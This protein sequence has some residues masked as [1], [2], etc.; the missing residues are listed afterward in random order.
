MKL[1]KTKL[2]RL[3][4][5]IGNRIINRI[6]PVLEHEDVLIECRTIQDLLGARA[7]RRGSNLCDISEG[8]QKLPVLKSFLDVGC[9]NGSIALA[10]LNWGYL[11]PNSEIVLV[12]ADPNLCNHCELHMRLNGL[13]NF[14]VI[15]AYVGDPKDVFHTADISV[16]GTT[17]PTNLST[18]FYTQ[19]TARIPRFEFV[20]PASGWP[21]DLVNID[22]EGG[23]FELMTNLAP[24]TINARYLFV[25]WHHPM[26]DLVSIR[27]WLHPHYRLFHVRDNGSIGIGFFENR[28]L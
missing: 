23:E 12:D 20:W 11:L 6:R 4:R 27:K 1:P 18:A 2:T 13:E 22:C 24:S 28:D 3:A 5:Q 14:R 15:N 16:V 26:S 10:L 17:H 7:V 21:W 8:I 9:N 25:E 19:S